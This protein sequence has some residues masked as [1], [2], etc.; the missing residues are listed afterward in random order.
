[1][2]VCQL[3]ETRC[4]LQ[5]VRRMISCLAVDREDSAAY[6]GT[7]TGDIFMVS[8]SDGHLVKQAKAELISGGVVSIRFSCNIG[9]CGGTLYAAGSDCTIVEVRVCQLILSHE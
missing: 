9:G 3:E 5:K 1:M 2:N 4:N 7:K 8:L 6:F